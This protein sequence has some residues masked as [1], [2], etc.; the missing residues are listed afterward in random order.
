MSKDN[1]I[2]S[3]ICTPLDE[4]YSLLQSLEKS[5]KVEI[6]EED[7][8]IGRK[9]L[10]YTFLNKTIHAFIAKKAKWI[11]ELKD[12]ETRF[13]DQLATRVITDDI[14]KRLNI[15]PKIDTY[16]EHCVDHKNELKNYGFRINEDEYKM[17]EEEWYKNYSKDDGINGYCKY[18][19]TYYNNNVSRIGNN[20]E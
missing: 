18:L 4:L 15:Y 3:K 13:V 11:H 14:I 19:L 8:I 9:Q 2:V 6:N 7:Y 20:N 17:L 1:Y 10:F 5:F 12:N 16:Y